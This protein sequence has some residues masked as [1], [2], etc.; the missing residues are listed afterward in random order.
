MFDPGDD[1]PA[2]VDGLEAVTLERADGSASIPVSSALCLAE[3]RQQAA[4]TEG[5]Y[6]LARAV[7][8]LSAAEL[9]EAPRV[10][11]VVVDAS[12]RR[13]TIL[14]VE[15]AAAGTRWRLRTESRG[16]DAARQ[17][18]IDI[19]QPV[20]TKT[21]SGDLVA[22]WQAVATGLAARIQPVAETMHV[23]PGRVWTATRVIVYLAEP[24]AVDAQCRIRDSQGRVYTILQVR[25]A[26]RNDALVEIDALRQP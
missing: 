15:R 18:T 9:P 23:Q 14:A 4:P 19:E 1:F 20:Y 8:H 17:D 21:E 7:W 2:V 5:V 12:Q 16:L 25:N 10:G 6:Q 11:D 22:T 26:G 3:R 13:W 24:G